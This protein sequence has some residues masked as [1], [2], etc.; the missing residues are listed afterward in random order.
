MGK[1]SEVAIDSIDYV[2][3]RVAELR[4]L[5]LEKEELEARLKEVNQRINYISFDSLVDVMLEKRVPKIRIDGDGNSPPFEAELLP[6]Y[7]A[8]I[9]A[10]WE[11]ERKLEAFRSLEE[12]GASDLIKT[13][14]T[15]S[16]P[17]GEKSEA[18]R[19][20]REHSSLRPSLDESVH[21]STLTAWVRERIEAGRQTPPLE[22]IGARVGQYVKIKRI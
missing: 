13:R 8:N 18:I 4:D 11:E 20:V 3:A 21:S 6:F 12:F 22:T 15:F 9:A 1:S 14:V 16:F 7:R 2:R 5:E 19:L 17:R 10:S